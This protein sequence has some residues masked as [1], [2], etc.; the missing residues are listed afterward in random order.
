M[1]RN[2]IGNLFG[3]SSV[4]ESAIHTCQ[5]HSLKLKLDWRLNPLQASTS[6]VEKMG[7]RMQLTRQAASSSSVEKLVKR[8]PGR[9]VHQ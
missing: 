1:F 9:N 3:K 6:S 8:A 4:L 5:S 2:H 7:K